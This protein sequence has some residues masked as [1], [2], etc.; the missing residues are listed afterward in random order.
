MRRESSTCPHDSQK[1]GVANI[2]ATFLI[3]QKGVITDRDL[4]AQKLEEK[5]NRQ[6]LEN[7]VDKLLK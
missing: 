3:N 2:P 6:L 7:K 4:P 1:L 5:I